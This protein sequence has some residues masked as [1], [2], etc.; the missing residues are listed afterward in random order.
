MKGSQIKMSEET[1]V[2]T[3][4]SGQVQVPGARFYFHFIDLHLGSILSAHCCHN[5]K[6]PA[7][8][9]DATTLH[10]TPQCYNKAATSTHGK[11]KHNNGWCHTIKKANTGNIYGYV[12]RIHAYKIADYLCFVLCCSYAF[13]CSLFGLKLSKSTTWQN[14]KPKMSQLAHFLKRE[15]RVFHSSTTD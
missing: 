3:S 6:P 12:F 13:V 4:L 14:N 7:I 11:N 1:K 9:T 10:Q 8:Y 15:R 5:Q 2:L